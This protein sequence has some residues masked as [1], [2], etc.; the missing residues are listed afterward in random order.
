[1]GEKTGVNRNFFLKLFQII[2]SLYENGE[3]AAMKRDKLVRDVKREALARM[4]DAARDE[5]DF[6]AVIAQWDHLDR[7]RER[8]ERY[9]E[10]QRDDKT[11]EVNYTDGMVFP[12][13]ISHPAW[14]ETIKG[15]FLSMIFDNAFEMWQLIEDWEIAFLVKNLTAKQK[16]VLFS[17]EVRLCSTTQIAFCTGKTDRAIRKLVAVSLEAIRDRL[18]KLIQEGIE[19]DLSVTKTKLEFLERF[20]KK[21]ALDSSKDG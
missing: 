21:A 7:N 17:S 8:K 4:E 1:M 19:A 14:R 9:H 5:K 15:D 10:M 16:D 13:P 12:V 2:F 11:L 18:A 3:G 20:K 6:R